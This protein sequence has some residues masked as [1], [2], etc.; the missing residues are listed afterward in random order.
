MQPVC[1]LQLG[2]LGAVKYDCD[3]LLCRVVLAATHE[4]RDARLARTTIALPVERVKAKVVKV[5]KLD[6]ATVFSAVCRE[7][8]LVLCVL[9]RLGLG[10]RCRRKLL[11]ATLCF[12]R[13]RRCSLLLFL[14][15]CRKLGRP[16]VRLLLLLRSVEICATSVKER[17]AC[18]SALKGRPRARALAA[19]WP[20]V[21]P[22]STRAAG[23]RLT[24]VL[25]RLRELGTGCGLHLGWSYEGS[26]RR[27][28]TIFHYLERL[29]A[30]E[31]LAALVEK[32]LRR[33]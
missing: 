31:R 21:S 14:G 16:G 4:Q 27:H 11:C 8:E 5:L 6:L 15:L 13:R 29:P 7:P 30:V 19:L 25:V 28:R 18:R 33:S 20:R 12:S 17:A 10:G 2:E 32:L 1:R 24:R 9:F 26:R 23:A 22:A 3:A